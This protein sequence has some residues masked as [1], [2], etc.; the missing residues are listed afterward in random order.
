MIRRPKSEYYPP[1]FTIQTI[2]YVDPAS[3]TL[4]YVELILPTSNHVVTAYASNS[5]DV[6]RESLKELLNGPVKKRESQPESAASTVT[7]TA[8]VAKP[9][10]KRDLDDLDLDEERNL[11]KFLHTSQSK[12]LTG[13]SAEAYE[14]S[15]PLKLINNLT[16][17]ERERTN[18]SK[19]L[20][21]RL[22]DKGNRRSIDRPDPLNFGLVLDGLQNEHPNFR[23]VIDLVRNQFVLS[24]KTDKK[25]RIPPILLLGPPGIGKTHFSQSLANALGT[26]FHRLGYDS[27]QT[28]STLLGSDKHWSN[29]SS[30]LLFEVIC[31]GNSLN[32]MLFLDEIDKVAST[33]SYQNP[34]A[35]L[36]SL[37]EPVSS[38]KVKDISLDFEFNASHVI[39]IAAA[40]DP[41]KIPST[42]RSRFTEFRVEAPTGSDALHIAKVIARRLHA[43]FAIAKFKEPQY[44]LV[45][46]VAHLT[47]REQRQVWERA[48]AAAVANSR[49]HIALQDLPADILLDHESTDSEGGEGWLH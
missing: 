24:E 37:L 31:L 18:R 22:S 26:P 21:L 23:E 45:R 2:H 44:S 29:T 36:H 1:G 20:Y 28:S 34:L 40:N 9:S 6:A 14:W 47:P 11:L 48:Y 42:I 41:L 49:D 19:K 12:D 8:L 5:I 17:P 46:L 10:A 3:K 43:S 39:W 7:P 15:A 27:D 25:F 30:G 16:S 13:I 4:A 35:S 32:P 33:T 38:S